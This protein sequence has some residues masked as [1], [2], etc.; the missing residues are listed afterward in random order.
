MEK[1]KNRKNENISK[2]KKRIRK[3]YSEISQGLQEKT[4]KMEMVRVKL[5]EAGLLIKDIESNLEQSQLRSFY[6]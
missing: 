5:S 1:I 6:E 3:I 4:M 2:S